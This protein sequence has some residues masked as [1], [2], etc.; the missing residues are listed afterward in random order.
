MPTCF[1]IVCVAIVVGSAVYIAVMNH[2][3]WNK[4]PEDESED[5]RE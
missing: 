5:R 2:Q 4:K 1:V 3:W